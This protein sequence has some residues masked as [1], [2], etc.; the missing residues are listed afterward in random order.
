MAGAEIKRPPV[1]RISA[2]QLGVLALSS[3]LIFAFDVVWAYS[4]ASGGLIAILPQ[5][6]FAARAFGG[7]EHILPR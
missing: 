3:T 4:V 2:V 1:F 6:Y 5:S 7:G